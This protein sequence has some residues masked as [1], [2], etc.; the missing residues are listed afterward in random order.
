MVD[1]ID[2]YIKK[3]KCSFFHFSFWKKVQLLKNLNSIGFYLN[4]F[5]S[6]N[7]QNCLILYLG[8]PKL[9]DSIFQTIKTSWF[10]IPDYQNYSILYHRLLKLLDSISQTTKTASVCTV[11]DND[12]VWRIE[13]WEPVFQS[14][15]S[16]I[17]LFWRA[18]P[19]RLPVYY[20]CITRI[21]AVLP[22]VYYSVNNF[23][24]E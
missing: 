7:Y 15:P 14:P 10:Y 19:I 13:E 1:Q 4:T 5:T 11:P 2:G 21:L 3:Y 18:Q 6:A 17:H 23:Y 20:Y 12:V 24:A 8:L 16:L 9:L 22:G